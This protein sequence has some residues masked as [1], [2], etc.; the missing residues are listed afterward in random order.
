MAPMTLARVVTFDGVG[1]DRIAQMREAM[2]GDR[3]EGLPASEI[4]LLYDAGASQATAVVFFESEEDYAAGDAVLSAMP[5][6]ETPGRRTSVT[7]YDVVV[8]RTS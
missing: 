6:S 4:M 1:E 8:R 7:K 3:P 5:T 2:S